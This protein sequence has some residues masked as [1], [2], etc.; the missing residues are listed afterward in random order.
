MTRAAIY[1]RISSD[2]TGRA[3]GVQRQETECRELAE[4]NGWEVAEVL[5]DND[6]SAYSGKKRP[7]YERLLEMIRTGQAGA[8]IAWHTDRLYR[9]SRDLAQL[10]DIANEHKI[11]IRTVT[12]GDIDLSTASGRMLARVVA[13]VNEHEVEHGQERMQL[14]KRAAAAEGRWRGGPKPFGYE[15][16]GVTIRESE[17]KEIRDA[18]RRVLQGGTLA[19]IAR[20]W[21]D[22][23]IPNTRG[24]TWNK[25]LVRAVLLR[26]RNAGLIEHRGEVVGRAQWPGILPELEWSACRAILLNPA[27]RSNP[28]GRSS[29]WLGSGLFLCGICHDGTTV[30]IGGRSANGGSVYRCR[31]VE[32]HLWRRA[33]PIDVLVLST[34]SVHLERLQ[35]AG[36]RPEMPMDEDDMALQAE[37]RSIE[38]EL[39]QLRD[40]FKARRIDLRTFEVTSAAWSEDLEAAWERLRSARSSTPLGDIM[41][42]PDI[43]EALEDLDLDRQRALVDL[44]LVV[45]LLP[46]RAGRQP[47]GGYFDARSIRVEPRHGLG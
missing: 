11:E 34:L 26:A 32:G 31:A 16:D 8:I 38:I 7:A 40:S 21:H 24:G 45:T 18:T 37:I 33:E 43:G 29:R 14:A 23:G 22:R 15:P 1:C 39:E 4:R 36:W 44:W 2:P 12:S 46:A 20:D 47:G 28:G 5:V 13:A 27:R 3:A 30:K 19:S 10:I 25:Q 9:R 35:A 42:A 41:D 17:A 6:I